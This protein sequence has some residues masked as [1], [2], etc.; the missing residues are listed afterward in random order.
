MYTNHYILSIF[1]RMELFGE[2]Q[3][4]LL[5]KLISAVQL[6][7]PESFVCH[8][9]G[10]EAYGKKFLQL[11]LHIGPHNIFLLLSVVLLSLCIVHLSILQ[12]RA[13]ARVSYHLLEILVS[14][15]KT[16]FS[17]DETFIT[18][19]LDNVKKC[20]LYCYLLWSQS[21]SWI[22]LIQPWCLLVLI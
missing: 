13:R 22:W 14:R 9:P 1:H 20:R 12:Y 2:K 7:E 16:V 6:T 21:Y 3:A 4:K 19:V 5:S 10:I 17:R 8:I 11:K 18:K 15:D